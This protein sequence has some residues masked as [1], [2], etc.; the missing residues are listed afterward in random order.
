M[1][2]DQLLQCVESRSVIR[3]TVGLAT[4]NPD[5][6]VCPPTYA[7]SKRGE[8]PY[9]AFRRAF[10]EGQQRDVVVLDSPQSQ[11]N[12]IET[13]LLDASR[14][15]RIAYPDIEIAFP[16]AF[17]EPV[18]SVLQLSHRIYDAVMRACMLDDVPFFET[19]IGRSVLQARLATATALFTHAPVTLTL[20]AWDSNGGGGPMAAKIPRLLTSEILGLDAHPADI[21]ATKFDPMDIRKDVA[22][23]VPTHDTLRRFELKAAGGKAGK[24]KPKKPSEFGFGSVPSTAVPRAAVINGAIQTSVLSCSG[25]R[26][27]S[28]PTD[29]GEVIAARDQAGRAVLAALTLFGLVAQNESGY[30]LRSRCELL[31]H[32]SGRLEMIGRTLQQVETVSLEAGTA[33]TL[34][35]EAAQHAA[36]HGLNFR[37]QVLKLTADDRLQELVHRSREAASQGD[38]A[39]EA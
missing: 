25:L 39:D 2:L 9:I 8:P 7:A 27:I 18:Y 22:E 32:D 33:R 5:G 31:P 1:N 14:A 36:Q 37:P 4:V 34:L 11:S 28:F 23:L 38:A 19:N 30:L 3:Y 35:A 29:D 6:I 17:G 15:G 26:H 10:V 12:R 13:A 24:E 20:G 16:A 21:S